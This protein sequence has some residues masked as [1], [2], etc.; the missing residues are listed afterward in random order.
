MRR[1]F[2]LTVG[3]VAWIAVLA[4]G[5]ALATGALAASSPTVVTSSATH[6]GQTSA[7]LNGTVNPNGSSTTY[8]FQW[9][10]TNAYGVNG[11]AHAAGS[12]TKAVTVHDTASPLIPG[13][14]YHFRLVASSRFGITSG[15]DRTF[16]TAGNPP[17]DVA[18]GPATGLSS[19]GATLTGVVNPNR[20]ATTWQFE[21][22]STTAYGLSTTARTLPA[23]SSAISVAAPVVLALN[24]GTIYHYRLV[25]SHGTGNTFVPGA[26]AIFMT[27]PR[28]RPVPSVHVVSRPRRLHKQPF[29]VA[30]TGSL[31]HPGWIPAQ[32]A[33]TGN[34][35]IRY[36]HRR[37]LA[38]TSF[39]P[40]QP[41]CTYASL[42]TFAHRHL[43]LTVHV[44]FFG[45]GYLAPKHRVGP[46]LRF[47]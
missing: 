39:A 19:T 17:P 31:S 20:Q 10:L 37:H 25:A 46:V 22:G 26:D 44:Q 34:V 45:N 12:G 1:M 27:F 29:T 47:T 11:K 42:V 2:E 3:L 16:K 40:V 13:T 33:C 38:A 28:T 41:N 9:G 43:A 8:F 36:M 21:I 7:V 4:L 5:A 15:A 14:V 35:L 30:T 18:T 6:V 24:P 23:T 32:F